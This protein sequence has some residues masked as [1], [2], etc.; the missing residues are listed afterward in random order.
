[1][2]YVHLAKGFEEIEA[3]T[4]VDLLRRADIDVKL[5]SVAEERIVEGAH[6]IKVEADIIFDDADYDSCEMIVLP[7]GMPGAENLR[8]HKGLFDVIEKFSQI[9]KNLAAICAAPMVLA[10]HSALTGK[11]A[12]IYPGFEKHLDNII[13][14]NA[15]IIEDGNVLTGKGP[16]FAM[17]FAL[18]IIEKIKGKETADD[19]AKGLLLDRG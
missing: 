14:I 11:T 18:A 2:V 15:E 7:G 6:G 19:V 8:Q 17:K 9:G 10:G 5:V 1:M 13:P 4:V 12:T 3:L 16:A